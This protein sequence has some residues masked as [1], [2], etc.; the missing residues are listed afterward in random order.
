CVQSRGT[1]FDQVSRSRAFS[2]L[3]PSPSAL[4]VGKPDLPLVVPLTNDDPSP[5]AVRR[6]AGHRRLLNPMKLRGVAHP[7]GERA[8]SA[9]VSWLSLS[10]FVR[11]RCGGRGTSPARQGMPGR[12]WPALRAVEELLEARSA[13]RLGTVE[14]LRAPH[15]GDAHPARR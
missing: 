9:D 3:R 1:S 7:H 6:D 15:F 13:Q 4:L 2:Y 10:W 11:A 14:S 5:G 12:R 8:R